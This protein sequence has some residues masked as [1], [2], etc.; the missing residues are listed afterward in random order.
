MKRQTQ[1][2]QGEANNTM[3]YVYTV[4]CVF[5]YSRPPVVEKIEGVTPKV[6]AEI[7]IPWKRQRDRIGERI[8]DFTLTG[9]YD[10]GYGGLGLPTLLLRFKY[11][12]ISKA[13]QKRLD[14]QLLHK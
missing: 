14:Q 1:H 2:Y 4:T 8:K 7:G 6:G 12:D 10:R 11:K 3:L 9:G 13:D 5:L